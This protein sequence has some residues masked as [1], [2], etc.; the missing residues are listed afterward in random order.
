MNRKQLLPKVFAGIGALVVTL[1]VL[2]GGTLGWAKPAAPYK[3]P[4]IIYWG[5]GDVGSAT[6]AVDAVVAEKIAP[7]L[8]SKIR[9]IPGNDAE[10][11]NMLRA[12]RAHI[13]YLG[14]DLFWSSMGLAHYS[15]FAFGPQPL[16]IIW[17]GWPNYGPTI[18]IA[19][20]ASGIKTPY[21]LKGKRLIRVVGSA[22]ST[23]GIR[24]TL[25]FGKLTLDDVTIV[26]VSTA[27]AAYK[28]LAEGK[29]DFT[30]GSNTAPGIYEAEAGPYG[31]YLVR[32]PHE[33]KEGW[34]RYRKII[35]Y[36]VPDYITIGAGVKKGE[37]IPTLL[38]PHPAT[39]TLAS[40]PDEFVY[41]I[42]KAIY[43]KINEICA[44]NPGLEGMRPERIIPEMTA[45]GPFHPGAVKF[46]KEVGI[47]KEPHEITNKRRLVQL[48]KV[49]KR[50][51]AYLE[52]AHEKM[53][54]TGKKVDP[55]KEWPIIV[56]QEIGLLP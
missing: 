32:Y 36:H 49:N 48:E 55:M 17:A 5:T 24:G 18:G 21:D 11:I 46:L 51:L 30:L 28:G 1:L 10:R 56:E 45:L 39:A 34:E 38:H 19:T 54:K 25:A 12:G 2:L 7:A 6:Y 22:W 20:A 16:R 29:G 26:D 42:C 40:Q 41:T 35:A 37:K 4:S 53:A 31:I 44:A 52:E 43:S 14:S 50:W 33:D 47:W 3:F 15:T 8:G 9:L 13:A 23:E 27:G